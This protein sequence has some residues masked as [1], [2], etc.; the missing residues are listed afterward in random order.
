MSRKQ[1]NLDWVPASLGSVPAGALQG[2]HT[3]DGEVLYIGR[4]NFEGTLICGK[5]CTIYILFHP[6]RPLG[7]MNMKKDS[8]IFLK[9]SVVRGSSFQ[10]Q[11]GN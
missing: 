6:F 4:Y 7:I 9:A 2:G 10:E 3:A 11:P 5:A 8:Y 1:E